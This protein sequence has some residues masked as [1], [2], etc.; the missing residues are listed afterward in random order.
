MPRM[1]ID[2]AGRRPGTLILG[3]GTGG[4]GLDELYA[5]DRALPVRAIWELM[6]DRSGDAAAVE[7]TLGPVLPARGAPARR[8]VQGVVAPSRRGWNPP[9]SRGGPVR[10]QREDRGASSQQGKD[11][12]AGD[13]DVWQASNGAN[14]ASG[15]AYVSHV[16]TLRFAASL[17]QAGQYALALRYCLPR[18]LLPALAAR[19]HRQDALE[20]NFTTVSVKV[21]GQPL[22]G[23]G[24][25][26]LYPTGLYHGHAG[27]VLP[28]AWHAI[29]GGRKLPLPAGPHVIEVALDKGLAWP[30][31]DAVL[32][33][34]EPGLWPMPARDLDRRL[35]HSALLVGRRTRGPTSSRPG[36]D[37]YTVTLHNRCDEPCRT[38][39][40]W[41]RR[42]PSARE[43][44]RR[45]PKL[46]RVENWSRS[47]RNPS[48]LLFQS[49][50]EMQGH[51]Q[52]AEI[53][54][55]NEDVACQQMYRLWNNIPVSGFERT[56]HPVRYPPPDPALQAR[57]REWL[58]RGIPKR[59][60]A[61]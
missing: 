55:W 48:R 27:D 56:V 1:T 19:Q 21:D 61:I 49:P 42:P 25:E 52:W 14:V 28:W 59:S 20:P 35:S 8:P 3:D 46:S 34:P 22:A 15:H 16:R 44:S 38:T 11:S 58:K 30:Y 7:E 5:V 24:L 51:C 37:T 41:S 6:Q 54:F 40:S 57:F 2:L 33:T 60:A 26:R 12:K 45:R 43:S 4:F 18:R 32:L 10:S 31:Y 39:R 23:D 36:I 50:T 53:H 9:R 17:P 29:G 47:A 13:A